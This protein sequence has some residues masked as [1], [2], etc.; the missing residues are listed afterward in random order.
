MINSKHYYK[1]IYNLSCITNQTFH[2]TCRIMSKHVTSLWCPSLH[3]GN[4]ATYVDVKAVV[5][6]L[7]CYVRFGQPLGFKLLTSCT[8]NTVLTVRPVPFNIYT[9]PSA[10]SQSIGNELARQRIEPEIMQHFH[11]PHYFLLL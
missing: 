10:Q 5:N 1:H 8:Q 3:Y 2:Y 4:T 6:R 9:C 11:S 7:Q